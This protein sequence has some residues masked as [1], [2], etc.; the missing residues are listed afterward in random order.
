VFV[1]ITAVAA[2]VWENPRVVSGVAG[3]LL[4]IS[5]AVRAVGDIGSGSLSWLSPMG[6]AQKARPYAG[7]RWWPL[8]LCAVVAGLLMV[9][10]AVLAEQRDF[11][12][13]MVAP[14]PGPARAASGLDSVFG[15]AVRLHRGAAFWWGISALAL[16]LVYGSL[17]NSIDDFVSDND[18][19]KDVLAGNGHASLT[20]SYLATSLLIVALLAAGPGLQIAL[21]LRTEEAG[22]RAEAILATPTSRR[23]WLGSHLT[24]ALA[25]SAFTLVLGGLGLGAAYAVTGGGAK[26]ILRMGAAS[27]A[28]LPA[29]WLVTAVAV[30]LFGAAPRWAPGAWVG[31][32]AC[33]VIAMFG[34]LL[35]PPSW[36]LDVSP[37]QHIPRLP[38]DSLRVGPLAVVGAVA[39]VLSLA[40]IARFRARDVVTS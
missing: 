35:D 15:L 34:P 2:Q 27:L 31:L 38:A 9:A 37:F 26:Q 22:L 11:G 36:V 3:G 10:A 19:L 8:A 28:Y 14:K 5:F 33:F 16:G 20:D 18:S 32:A 6:W 4:G 1:A 29:V 24:A 12:M 39:L 17:A 30:V 7:E 25:G 13:G 40:G 23:A 21:R